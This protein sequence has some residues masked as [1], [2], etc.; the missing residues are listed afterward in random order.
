MKLEP[1]FF[2][3]AISLKASIEYNILRLLIVGY[4]TYVLKGMFD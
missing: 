2:I 4:K 3:K 1:R